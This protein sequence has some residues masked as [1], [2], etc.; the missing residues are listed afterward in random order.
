MNKRIILNFSGGKDSTAMLLRWIEEG[1]RLDEVIYFNGGWEFPD[2]INHIRIVREYVESKSIK[3][4]ELCPEKTLEDMLQY[5]GFPNNKIRWCTGVK[6]KTIDQYLKDKRSTINLIGIAYDELDR[7][8]ATNNFYPL[9]N[10]KMTEEDCL[11]YCYEHGYT[12]NGLYEVFNRVS[13]WCC[14]LQRISVLRKLRKYY[15]E[16]WEKL[17]IY[18]ESLT[19]KFPN[20]ARSRFKDSTVFALDERLKSEELK[21]VKHND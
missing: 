16:L 6:V 15:P 20:D 7:V 11:K 21:Y 13:C 8:K 1:R 14:P 10:W 18:Q 3:F 4:T 17:L 2:M 9:I 12:W 5:R 19:E